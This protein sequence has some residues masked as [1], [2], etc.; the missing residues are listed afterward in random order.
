M[1]FFFKSLTGLESIE[2]WDKNKSAE[3]LLDI[4]ES[5]FFLFVEILF[6]WLLFNRG[7]LFLL[8][9]I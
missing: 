1:G 7:N 2:C 8:L 6:T 5:L 4:S 3:R 9:K